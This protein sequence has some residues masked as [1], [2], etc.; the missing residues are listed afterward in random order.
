M[1][2][3]SLLSV[4]LH[5]TIFGHMA[6]RHDEREGEF[7][8]CA[9]NINLRTD[10]PH[11]VGNDYYCEAGHT[12]PLSDGL[13]HTRPTSWA[14]P[15][16]DGEGYTIPE[17]RCC[18]RHGWFHKN[19]SSTSDNIEVRWYSNSPRTVKDVLTDLVDIWVL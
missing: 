15:L 19:V 17:N 14:D 8:S 3:A 9:N 11:F 2:M 7:C 13:Y 4:D 5:V 6:A 12:A 18:D 10:V 16:W 1:L